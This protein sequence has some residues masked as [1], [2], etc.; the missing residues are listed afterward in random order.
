M[1]SMKVVSVSARS[2]LVVGFLASVAIAL[3]PTVSSAATGYVPGFGTGPGYCA[4]A[5]S[6]GY[7]LG[8]Q[9]NNVY[10]C[11]PVPIAH[12]D[13]GPAIPTFWP[14]SG[15]AGGFQCTELAQRYLYTMTHGD[16]DNFTGEAGNPWN[17]LAGEGFALAASQKYGFALKKSTSGQ[18]PQVGDIISEAYSQANRYANVGDVGIVTSVTSTTITIMAENNN[19]AGIN[20]ITMNSP[21]N[22]VINAGTPYKYT[23]FEWV[24][25]QQG[26]NGVGSAQ[27]LGNFL[28]AGQR[29]YP[30]QYLESGNGLAVLQLQP[31]GNLVEYA[32]NGQVMWQSGTAGQAIAY[33]ILQGD[34]NF[35]LYRT[36]GTAAFNTR[37]GGTPSRQLVL[38][39]DGNLVLYE[40]IQGNQEVAWATN[41]LIP[42]NP[43]SL[44]SLGTDRLYAG[45]F[46]YP[47]QFIQS[48]DRRYVLLLQGD[49]NLVLYG[50]GYHVLWN[51]GTGGQAIRYGVMQGD[52]NFV[53]YR[54]D[55]SPAFNTRTG[56]TAANRLVMQ[57]D[58]NLVLYD[59]AGKYY[60]ASWT[61]G[62][63]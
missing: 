25:L 46:I 17:G 8:P 57:G 32:M 21:T 43:A 28:G 42:G 4:A 41:H 58:G 19:S 62:K 16:L 63:I 15:Q 5:A 7:R 56:S 10:A 2:A 13:S 22:W 51:A 31:D 52:G 1:N 47:G 3:T 26:W 14:V 44:Q 23:Y 39:N 34:G 6:G 33:G 45:H 37:T 50:P 11:G 59:A 48:G 35:V 38:Q 9:V 61:G 53:L 60:W 30:N 40:T 24:H 27:F 29:I 55:G 12:Y 20:H 49:G 54:T 18:V 36:N